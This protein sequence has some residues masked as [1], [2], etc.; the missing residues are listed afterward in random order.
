MLVFVATL[1]PARRRRGRALRAEGRA[2]CRAGRE[3]P[4]RSRGFES[5]EAGSQR[6][7]RGAAAGRLWRRRR[8]EHGCQAVR[9][10]CEG[11]WGTNEIDSISRVWGDFVGCESLLDCRAGSLGHLRGKRKR[12][13]N[14]GRFIFLSGP[15]DRADIS[16]KSRNFGR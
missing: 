14:L 11:K 12:P 10:L 4:W 16:E 7:A 2:G 5:S 9:C 3:Q 8:H 1:V 6:W 15:T 13:V